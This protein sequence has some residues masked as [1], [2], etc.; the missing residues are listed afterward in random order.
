MQNLQKR[1]DITDKTLDFSSKEKNHFFVSV[2]NDMCGKE[3]CW[4][5]YMP[6]VCDHYYAQT[7]YSMQVATLFSLFHFWPVTK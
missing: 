3:S 1:R 5:D 4:D 7:T 6:T 2:F